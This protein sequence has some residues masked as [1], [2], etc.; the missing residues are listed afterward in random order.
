MKISVIIP[1]HNEESVIAKTLR[2]V[3]AQNHPDF[4][5]IVVN[6]ASTDNTADIV[7]KFPVRLV[8]ESK[9]GLLWARER[10]RIEASGDII[11]NIDADCLPDSD[12]L[13]RGSALFKNEEISAVTG[14]YDYYDG[15]ALF[16]TISLFTQKNIYFSVNALLQLPFI[17]GGAVLIGGNNFIRTKA[18]S[19]AGGYNTSILFYGEDTDTAKRVARHGKVIFNRSL[20]MKTSARRFK[21][22]GTFNITVKYIFHFFKTIFFSGKKKFA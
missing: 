5:V 8:R 21:A 6:N 15:T 2:A 9:K 18:I 16:R 7:A 13:I 4:E 3:L 12:W 20:H 17:R 22:E 1:A 11:A 10:G 19:K 14:P